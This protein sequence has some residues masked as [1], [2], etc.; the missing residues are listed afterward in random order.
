MFVANEESDTIVT[1]SVGLANG[2]LGHPTVVATV[3]SPTCIVFS[4]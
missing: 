1:M 2:A 3:G 4:A